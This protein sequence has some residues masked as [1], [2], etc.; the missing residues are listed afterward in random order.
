MNELPARQWRPTIRTLIVDGDERSR[1]ALRTALAAVVDVVLVGEVADGA[2]ALALIEAIQ[3]DLLFLDADAPEPDSF[4]LV[5]RLTGPGQPLV[6]FTTHQPQLE[7]RALELDALDCLRKP[8]SPGRVHVTVNHARVRLLQREPDRDAGPAR[9]TGTPT[10]DL[11]PASSERKPLRRLAVRH[12]SSYVLLPVAE[13]ESLEAAG[14]YV[15]VTSGGRSLLMRGSLSE[16]DRRLDPEQFARVHRSTIVNLDQV[17]QITP[18][19]SG[20][21]QLLLKSGRVL[22]MSR[23]YRRRLLP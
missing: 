16:L 1:S 15:R 2:A 14:N 12:R 8:I 13:V 9:P 7:A 19:M 23:N 4:G 20:D 10:G 17:R 11:A 5:N 21:Y 18:H 3:P 22:R 6:V